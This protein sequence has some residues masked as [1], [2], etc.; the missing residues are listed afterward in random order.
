MRK[1]NK[2]ILVGALSVILL[3]TLIYSSQIKNKTEVFNDDYSCMVIETTQEKNRTVFSFYDEKFKLSYQN[4][5][6]YS[7]Y[8]SAN[9]DRICVEGDKLY[10]APV[11][12]DWEGKN[13]LLTIDLVN[14]MLV[15]KT[16][17]PDELDLDKYITVKDGEVYVNSNVNGDSYICKVDT[18]GSVASYIKVDNETLGEMVV[19]GDRLYSFNYSEDGEKP[20]LYIFG[21]ND[22][23]KIGVIEMNCADGLHP[24]VSDGNVFFLTND[25]D[26]EKSLLIGKYNIKENKI[27]CQKIDESYGS[28]YSHLTQPVS[29]NGELWFVASTEE[30][31]CSLYEYELETGEVKKSLMDSTNIIQIAFSGNN[32]YA[33]VDDEEENTD[34]IYIQKY[35]ITRAE[36]AL[37]AQYN[38]TTQSKRKE[39]YYG[40]GF[41]KK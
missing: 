23:K 19:E 12:G 7:E 30:G 18:E 37:I 9:I 11:D 24:I 25:I 5:I 2:L 28:G 34:R 8:V 39:L 38:V 17:L 3:F 4:E 32:L 16:H 26:N 14:G 40:A 33:L 41:L 22:L 31:L 27:D 29:A 10:C 20:K 15:N 1:Y 36:P 6:P 21:K 13:D 35:D